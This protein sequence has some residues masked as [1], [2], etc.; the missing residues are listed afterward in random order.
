MK[1]FTRIFVIIILFSACTKK[2]EVKDSI[3]QDPTY[4]KVNSYLHGIISQQDYDQIDWNSSSKGKIGKEG[5]VF[6]V[7]TKSEN[8]QFGSIV[9]TYTNNKWTSNYYLES[10]D[11]L[12]KGNPTGTLTITSIDRKIIAEYYFVEGKNVALQNQIQNQI[13]S[14]RPLIIRPYYNAVDLP[15]VTVTATLYN[16]STSSMLRSLYW[17]TN[18]NPSM[19]DMFINESDQGGGTYYLN[20]DI[21]YD[22]ELDDSEDRHAIDL[23]KLI[24]CFLTVPDAGATYSVQLCADVPVNSHPSYLINLGG[25]YPAPGHVFLIMTKTTGAQSMTQVF[26][27]YPQY[28]KKS[29]SFDPVPSTIKDD[30][31]HEYNASIKMDNISKSDFVAILAQGIYKSE[32]ESYDLNG[33]NCTNF[34]LDAFNAGRASIGSISVQK[35]SFNLGLTPVGL[36]SKLSSMK[37]ANGPEASNIFLGNATAPAGHGECN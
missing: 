33:Y 10:F 22:V 30:T 2:I 28:G 31:N 5:F 21:A 37:S 27:F 34:A 18:L 4:Q 19:Y 24:D 3:S 25:G 16:T 29:A 20:Y 36:Y 8:K 13:N 11:D 15:P 14:V 26:G 35:T 12:T 17:L 9:V 32:A 1:N 7:R 23:Q 6:L